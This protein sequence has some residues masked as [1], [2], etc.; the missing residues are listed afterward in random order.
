MAPPP[1]VIQTTYAEL[2]DRSATTAFAEAFPEVGVFTPKTIK[3]RRYWYFQVPTEKGR[4]QKYVGSETPEL[5][6]RIKNHKQAREDE[7]ERRALVSALI[8]FGL[9]RPIP[10]IGNIVAALARAGIF[11]LRGILVGTVAYQTYPA[12]LVTKFPNPILQTGDVDIAQYRNVSA[13]VGDHTPPIIDILK[14]VD[15]TFRAVPHIKG[16]RVANY[17]AKGGFRVEFLTPNQ[18]ADTDELRPL[19]AFQTDAQPFRFLDFLI[20][21]PEP[22][23]ILHD[24][25]IY[26]QVPSPERFAVHKLII[27]RRR[28]GGKRD[29]DVRQAESLLEVLVEKRPRE[30][31]QVWEEANSRGQGWRDL[32]AE[33]MTQLAARNRDILLRHVGAR[34]QTLPGIDFTFNNPPPHYDLARDIVTFV[35]DSIGGPVQGAISREALDDH[36]GSGDPGNEGRVERFLKNRSMIEEMARTK[37][38]SWP[39]EE[40]NAVLIK[41]S[42]VPKL[43]DELQKGPG[44]KRRN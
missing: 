12:L 28:D 8:R 41:T 17:V 13:A 3:G 26:V 36:F 10:E 2:L 33:G 15:T 43:R 9:P 39:V 16:H 38:L 19:P 29:K 4:A 7:R 35:G 32:L 24:A 25:G 34:R 21:D 18:G 11:R 31:K 5:L 23:A 6:E 44:P 37:Y 42:D 22:A 1:L 40:P 27:S 20:H 14:Q 30:L